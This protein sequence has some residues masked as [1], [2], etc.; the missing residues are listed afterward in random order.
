MKR[1]FLLKSMLLL[2]ALVVGS[3]SVWA[4]EEPV[5]LFR[6]TFGSTTSNTA[7]ASYSGFTATTS[8]FTTTGQ[9]KSHYSGSGSVGKN[10]LSA[11]NLSSG[12][13]GASGNSGCYHTGTAN[14]ESTIIQI[15]NINIEGYESLKLSFGVLG[16]STNHKINVSYKIDNGS[17]TSLIS[18]GSITNANWILKSADMSGTGKSLTL[19]F[20]HKPTSAWTIRMDDI[21]VT[22]IASGGSSTPS[23]S[24]NDVDID[25]N[26]TNGSI[27]Y[28]LNSATGNV[29]ASVTSGDWLT[30]GT[31]TESAVPF[32]CSAN[33]ETTARTATVTLSFSGATDKV[34]TVTQAAYSPVVVT[35]DLTTNTDWGF[36]TSKTEGPKRIKSVKFYAFIICKYRIILYSYR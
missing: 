13:T 19:I 16:N 27:A 30:L 4:D 5:T 34:V 12:Y 31:I 7:F 15:S 25:Y 23:I 17:E 20:K 26:A 24:A 8:M 1:T 14:T 33:T 10:S 9:V 35:L 11:A 36:P 22:G 3:S 21:K 29:S 32:T 18:D 6:E 28:T 2:C